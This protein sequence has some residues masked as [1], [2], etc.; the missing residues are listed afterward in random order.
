MS[1][2]LGRS[3]CL[4]PSLPH[5]THVRRSR[6]EAE[7]REAAGLPPPP[8]STLA[9]WTAAASSSLEAA[10]RARDA[11][12]ALAG[13]GAAVARDA[14]DFVEGRTPGGEVPDSLAALA[15]LAASPVSGVGG[16]EGGLRVGAGGLFLGHPG[17]THGGRRS[18]QPPSSRLLHTQDVA[19]ATASLAAAATAGALSALFDADRR[20]PP[21]SGD[22][23]ENQ[24]QQPQQQRSTTL[25]PGSSSSSL[26]ALARGGRAE[27][28]VIAAVSAACKA[29][30]REYL[31][32]M[33]YV[34]GAPTPGHPPPHGPTPPPIPRH[35]ATSPD[36]AAATLTLVKPGAATPGNA[37]VAA[38][39]RPLTASTR[40]PLLAALAAVLEWAASPA[41]GAAVAGAASAAS[42]AAVGAWLDRGA[43]GGGWGALV[44]AV[45]A[46]DN[47]PGAERLAR[48]G[49][50]ECVAALL[51]SAGR[52]SVGASSVSPAARAAR[53]R[54]GA[55]PPPAMA[56]LAGGDSAAEEEGGEEGGWVGGLA[57]LAR[58]PDARALALSLAA[59]SASA[60]VKTALDVAG[61]AV[62]AAPGALRAR[63]TGWAAERAKAARL[64][65]PDGP[66]V[67][68]PQPRS[69]PG[70]ARSTTTAPPPPL[71]LAPALAIALIGALL[72][73]ALA[74][75]I[76]RRAAVLGGLCG[77]GGGAGADPLPWLAAAVCPSA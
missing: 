72:A 32:A 56:A 28:L 74:A 10:A 5:T 14:A 53:L 21:P 40:D 37:A 77:G 19:R 60:G 42:A 24:Q 62:A 71:P 47:V 51:D 67:P 16:A 18:S 25:T 75:A 38:A 49:A 68:P 11:V 34:R 36:D 46:P 61:S 30:T 41:G 15:R 73:A 52:G 65:V 54:H 64:A 13:L 31:D 70:S 39:L 27:A 59:A 1:L 48:A 12:A 50:A 9:R 44:A 20:S 76:L 66:P 26:A 4:A 2:P 45:C 33:G 8:P 17:T 43:A 7:E 29:S 3:Q 6:R 22:G 55:S 23:D 57:R 35:L 63:V 69:R 58:A